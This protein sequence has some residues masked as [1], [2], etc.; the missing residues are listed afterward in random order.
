MRSVSIAPYV[1]SEVV[2]AAVVDLQVL[3]TVVGAILFAVEILLLVFPM[4][5]VEDMVNTVSLL[6][7]H[8]STTQTSQ[9]ISRCRRLYSVYR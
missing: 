5:K 1:F 2:A 7:T 9:N 4:N 6:R 8:T 3:Q